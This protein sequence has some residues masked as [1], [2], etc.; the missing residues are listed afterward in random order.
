MTALSPQGVTLARLECPDGLR[1]W[2]AWSTDT[3][4]VRYYTPGPEDFLAVVEDLVKQLQ[5]TRESVLES[6]AELT[7]EQ[8]ADVANAMGRLRAALVRLR[9]ALGQRVR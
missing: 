3:D 6:A 9:S 5:E 2:I 1:K 7:P 4:K 8:W